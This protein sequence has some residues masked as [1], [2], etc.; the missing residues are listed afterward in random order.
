MDGTGCPFGQFLKVGINMT[1]KLY[2]AVL[3]G[4]AVLAIS[5]GATGASAATTSATATAKIIQPITIAQDAGLD[6]GV[7]VP[8][9]NPGTVAIDTGGTKTC[10]S[11]NVSCVSGGAAGAFTA[12]GTAAQNVSISVVASSSLTGPGTAMTLDGL[13][14]SA[15]T[16]TLN[17]SGQVSFTVGGTLH[18]NANQAAGT[19]NGNYDVTVNYS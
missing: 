7:I 11:A 6:F 12:T 18:V 5:M 3:A 8:S 2:S 1:K 15:S 13:A 4:T 14:T 16:G 19:Y 9:I 17:G 10:D